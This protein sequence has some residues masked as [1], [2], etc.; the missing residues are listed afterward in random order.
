VEELSSSRHKRPHLNHVFICPR[1]FTQYWRKCLYK[2]ADIILELPPG[3]IPEWPVNMHE[4]LLVALTL[5]FATVPPW[6]LRLS[7][8]FLALGWAVQDMWR[9]KAKHDRHLLRQLCCFPS[10]LECM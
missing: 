7:S 8:S 4:P 9:R 1:L 10:T 5:R 2:V 6:Q 3:T